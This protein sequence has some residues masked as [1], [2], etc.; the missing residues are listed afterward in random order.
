MST[1]KVIGVA[2][3]RMMTCGAHAQSSVTL[4]G[5]IDTGIRY[6]NNGH[7]SVTTMNTNGWLSSS[8]VGFTGQ[9]DRK[10]Y[11]P[12]IA[13]AFSCCLRSG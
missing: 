6:T 9:E 11:A 5:I 3:L 2:A 1:K 7:G 12:K 4:Y 10:G 8:R 13:G